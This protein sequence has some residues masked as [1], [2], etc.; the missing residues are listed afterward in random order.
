MSHG[1]HTASTIDY[2]AHDHAAAAVAAVVATATAAIVAAAASA[3]ARGL[4]CFVLPI[5]QEGRIH[6]AAAG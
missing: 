1:V 5:Q 3:T 6:G 4:M 2:S